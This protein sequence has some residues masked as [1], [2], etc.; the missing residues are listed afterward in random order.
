MINSF[1]AGGAYANL[2]V[3]EY[4]NPNSNHARHGNEEY[5]FPVSAKTKWSF[6]A[7]LERLAAFL[8]KTPSLHPAAIASA[9]Q[10][11][12]SSGVSGGIYGC[13]RSGTV[14]KTGRL[15]HGSA[16]SQFLRF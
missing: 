4:I 13:F 5:I 1:G 6:E 11:N 16:E 3:E 8:E 14:G 9:L 2:I 10:K 12:A 15:P 7:Y